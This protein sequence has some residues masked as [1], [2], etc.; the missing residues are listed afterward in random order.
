LG[1][2]N[3]P[4]AIVIRMSGPFHDGPGGNL[5]PT[6]KVTLTD[7]FPHDDIQ[8]P[9]DVQITGLHVTAIDN[10][11]KHATADITVHVVDDVPEASLAA[12]SARP[13]SHE[14][15]RG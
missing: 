11:H 12:A 7:H 2:P 8:G 5:V 4:I 9:N 13:G 3:G 6:L 1:G 15:A 10:N 14:H